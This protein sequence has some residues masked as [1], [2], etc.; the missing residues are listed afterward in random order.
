VLFILSLSKFEPAVTKITLAAYPALHR[1][2]TRKVCVSG[3]FKYQQFISQPFSHPCIPTLSLRS[4]ESCLL[5]VPRSK[6]VFGSQAF[7]VA[8]PTFFNLLTQDIRSCVSSFCRQLKTIHFPPLL[9]STPAT[10]ARTSD[11]TIGLHCMRCEAQTYLT[12]TYLDG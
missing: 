4:K 7:C 6:T 1:F 11:S 5:A 3:M 2:Q 10:F 8:A 12:C 9:Q